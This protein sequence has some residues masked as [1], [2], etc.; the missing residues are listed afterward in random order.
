MNELESVKGADGEKRE[1]IM[2]THLPYIDFSRITLSVC[3]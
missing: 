3:A 1:F 2:R